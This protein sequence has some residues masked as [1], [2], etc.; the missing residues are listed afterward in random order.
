[1]E[2]LNLE[3]TEII[4]DSL[5]VNITEVEVEE[6][7]EIMCKENDFSRE[8]DGKEYR[9]ISENTIEDTYYDEQL[10]LIKELY[11][12]NENLPWWIEIDW[13]RTIE[14]VFNADGYGNFF[15]GYDGSEETF[16]FDDELWYV[17]RTN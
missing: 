16:S 6:L 4:N 13:D 15:S 11:F 2:D 1:M 3:L 8:I 17:F 5:S 10:E 12:P 14:N 7:Y 9:F